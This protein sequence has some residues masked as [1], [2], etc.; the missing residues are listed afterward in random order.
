M[1]LAINEIRHNR[2]RY[3]LV[4]LVILLIAYLVFFLAGLSNGLARENRSAIDTWKADEI[5]L[6]DDSNGTLAM[7]SLDPTEVSA[8]RATYKATLSQ[9]SAV[10]EKDADAS[11]S[12][13][14]S[15]KID[16]SLLGIAIDGFLSPAVSDGRMF[17]SDG[18]AVVDSTLA[19]RYGVRL[20]DRL[21]VA[22]T[23]GRTVKVVGFTKDAQLSVAPVVYMSSATLAG[24]FSAGSES[25]N[26]AAGSH[27]MAASGDATTSDGAVNAVVVR[28]T[29][30]HAPSNVVVSSMSDFIDD[31]PGYRAQVLTFG[32][33]IGFLIGIAAMVVGVFVY[34]LTLQKRAVF[35]V[36]K[37]QGISDAFLGRSIVA[38]TTILS[39]V[40]V[41][42]GAA[43]TWGTSLALPDAVPYRADPVVI[44][45]SGAL[46]IASALMAA[47][48]SVSAMS[49]IDPVEAIG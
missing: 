31:L 20:G 11:G 26:A 5:V 28:G 2:L 21:V 7:S 30:R 29:V 39:L 49:R 16:A 38:Q 34:V 47:L 1:F 33:M 6:S 32:L 17:A 4:V 13:D 27:G 24:L 19:S 37:A 41:I 18:E 45:L 44:A 10:V 22:Q 43:G 48:F 8:I 35:G 42:A 9:R 40:G 25:S 23:G 3:A 12:D 36:M 14:S 46:L 15:Q